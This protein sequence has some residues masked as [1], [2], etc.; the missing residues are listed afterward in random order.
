MSSSP[1]IEKL[2]DELSKLVE[3]KEKAV[4]V[5]TLEINFELFQVQCEKFKTALNKKIEKALHTYLDTIAKFCANEINEI[6]ASYNFIEK[7]IMTLPTNEGE[8][9]ELKQFGKNIKIKKAE[10]QKQEMN[11][12][13]H[14][15]ILEDYQFT[16]DEE[17]SIQLWMCKNLPTAIDISAK[18]GISRLDVE[19]EKFR[20]KLEKEKDK[21]YKEISQLHRDFEKIQQFAEYEENDNNYDLVQKLE[22][23]LNNAMEQMNSFNQ[24][25]TLFE[26]QLS[27]KTELQ[28]MIDDFAPFNN[29]WTNVN[30]FKYGLQSWMNEKKIHEL[31]ASSISSDVDRWLREC[32]MLNKK[33]LEKSPE[34]INVINHL[35]EHL[36]AFQENIPLIKSIANE[37]W[38]EDHWRRLEVIAQY[39][40]GFQPKLETVTSLIDKGMKKFITEIEEISYKAQREFKLKKKLE[41]M[42][43]E[44]EL[45]VLDILAYK[46]TFLIKTIEEIQVILDEQIVNV[47][48]MKT[49][50]Y[51]KPIE[52]QCKEWEYRITNIQETLEQ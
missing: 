29:L 23:D 47:Q 8:L 43:H 27:D 33:L 13:Q 24:R 26:L 48:A 15:L 45:Q 39:E 11:V 9:F 21:W 44:A 4:N 17:V 5:S 42:K 6:H 2:R 10:L 41:E 22:S 28:N 14:T 34:A 25:E 36:L 50:P 32:F 40:E 31:N 16:L 35:K 7:K 49:S 20:E 12:I 1:T 37:A 30:S 46:D 19:E 52:K 3:A 51:A 38:G 18:E